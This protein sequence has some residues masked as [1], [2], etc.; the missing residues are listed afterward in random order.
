MRLATWNIGSAVRNIEDSIEQIKES[1]ERNSID[2]ICFQEAITSGDNGKFLETVKNELGYEY[3]SYFELSSAHIDETT[4]MGVAILSRYQIIDYQRILL[5]NPHL[6][7]QKG[8]NIIYSDDKGFLCVEIIYKGKNIRVLTGHMLPFHSFGSDSALHKD[9]YVEM[10]SKIKPYCKGIPSIICGD[11]NSSKLTSIIPDLS[12]DFQNTFIKPTRYNGNQNDYIFAST[13]WDVENN[14]IEALATFDHFLCIVEVDLKSHNDISI[15][16][17]SDIHYGS[18]DYSIDQKTL[19]PNVKE[20][21]IR[22]TEFYH[23][24]ESIKDSIN[25]VVVTGDI[26]TKGDINGYSQFNIF[27]KSMQEKGIFPNNKHFVIVPG[28]HDT[29]REKKWT[30]YDN[31]LGG[32]VVRPWLSKRDMDVNELI[33]K[34]SEVEGD[35]WGYSIDANTGDEIH[36]PILLDTHN[37]VL[38]YCFNSSSISQSTIEL[39]QKDKEL[40]DRIKASR[41]NKDVKRL[42]TLLEEELKVDPARIDPQELVLFRRI[43]SLL[44]NKIDLTTYYKIAVFHHHITNISCNEE[45]K[46]FDEILNGGQLKRELVERNF[47]I[48]LHGHKHNPDVFYDSAIASHRPLLVVAGGTI[49]GYTTVKHGYYLHK[50]KNN[51][52]TSLFISLEKEYENKETINKLGGDLYYK[53]GL[54]LSDI[55]QKV[56]NVVTQHINEEKIQDRVYCGWS[57]NIENKRVGSISTAYGILILESL[58]AKSNYYRR[59]K[60]LILDSLW[61]F[62]HINGGWGAVSQITNTGAPEATTWIALAFYR[63]HSDKYKDALKDLY[64]ILDR[65]QDTIN[66]N[67]TFALIIIVLCELDPNSKWI[68]IC[69]EKLLDSAVMEKNQI[70]YW[71]TK[72]KPDLS[73]KL[74]PSSI[75]TSIAI[76]ALYKAQK[77]G[78]ISRNLKEE[79]KRPYELLTRKEM[80]NNRREAISIQ[81]GEKEDSLIVDYYTVSWILRAIM[82]KEDYIDLS[83]IQDLLNKI[84]DDYRNGYWNYDGVYYIWT[85]YDA[86]SAIN[87]VI[88]MK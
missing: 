42:V 66:S 45:I 70:H 25:Y 87:D 62:R 52:M 19:L 43:M 82:Y 57:K 79:L 32:H 33:R 6:E 29:D 35:I 40:I 77:I 26:T 3:L 24:I 63:A 23:S 68:T 16:H 58:G 31:V 13:D 51:T 38:I 75:H 69:C 72:C 78:A 7:I 84:I 10:Y 73:Y 54:F 27:V 56:E 53:N 11:F 83:I 48:L 12:I 61:S 39:P 64:N 4:M 67:F 65:M 17:L 9:V 5:S 47:Q 37:H 36:Y 30:I 86:L 18:P 88:L 44:E 46:K 34:F 85:I 59:K 50:L 55:Y 49:F 2:I 20:S 15:L 74:E 60:Q 22:T 41:M 71:C 21:D 1:V 28:N 8:D 76:I 14:H 81:I 80:W